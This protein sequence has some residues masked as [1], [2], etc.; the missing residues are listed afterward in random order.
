VSA[1]HLWWQGIEGGTPLVEVSATLEVLR[2]PT[3]QRLYFWA[4]Q[5]SFISDAGS[6]G[7]GHIGLQWNPRHAGCTAVNWGGYADVADVRSVLSGSLSSLPSTP[8]DPNTRDFPWQESTP[9]RLRVHRVPD[10]WRGEVTDLSSGDVFHVR[11]LHAPGDRLG[12]FVVWAE[13]FASCADP[14]TVVQWS[15][16]E[17]RAADGSVRSPASV[18]VTFPSGGD[19]PN[20]DVIVNSHG[21]LQITN[22]QRTARDAAVLPV[23]G[24]G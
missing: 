11:D 19:C 3:A 17:A 22:T 9:Y 14:Q 1:F 16:F 23:P 4:L 24:G 7:A 21:L 2:R 12:G 8:A 5:A 20:T 6:H 10:G 18:R 13:V 15:G